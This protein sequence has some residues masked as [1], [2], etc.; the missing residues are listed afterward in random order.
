[1]SALDKRRLSSSLPRWSL[2]LKASMELYVFSCASVD[3]GL[4]ETL[5]YR[6]HTRTCLILVAFLEI[7]I[8]PPPLDLPPPEKNMISV[9]LFQ[10]KNL[11][12]RIYK[13]KIFKTRIA[14]AKSKKMVNN[15][16]ISI[17]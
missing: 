6:S 4:S 15:L 9:N 1:M 5:G 14:G 3:S 12:S 17:C 16:K 13:K 10:Q 7:K 11:L 8:Q 2:S